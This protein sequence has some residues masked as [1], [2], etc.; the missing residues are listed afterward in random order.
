MSLTCASNSKSIN[1]NESISTLIDLAVARH[2]SLEFIAIYWRHYDVGGGGIATAPTPPTPHGRDTVGVHFGFFLLLFRV[3][4]RQENDVFSAEYSV[5]SRFIIRNFPY[6]AN[7]GE[8]Q[9]LQRY[10]ISKL[11]LD[12]IHLSQPETRNWILKI[13]KNG[14]AKQH[15]AVK[16][17]SNRRYRSIAKNGVFH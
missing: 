6:H 3:Q 9:H 2:F 7:I 11:W 16:Y 14:T 12:W 10:E 13:A 4:S 15:P 17:R 8:Y 5:A 1:W